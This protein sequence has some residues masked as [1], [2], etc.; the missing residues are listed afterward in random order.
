M[1]LKKRSEK[2][3]NQGFKESILLNSLKIALIKEIK[4]S[5]ELRI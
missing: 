1:C 2:C 4:K 5:S 3:S